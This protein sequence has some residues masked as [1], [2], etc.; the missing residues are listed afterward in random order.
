MAAQNPKLFCACFGC[1]RWSRKFPEGWSFLCRDHWM[2]L[3]KKYRLAYGRARRRHLK[4]GTM[5][6]WRSE[7]RI[8]RRCVRAATNE[9]LMG[10]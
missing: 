6:T 3:P 5:A 4:F 2:S 9:A 8:W 1:K 7:G 10:L